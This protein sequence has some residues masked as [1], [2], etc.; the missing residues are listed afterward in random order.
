M[1]NRIVGRVMRLADFDYELPDERIAQH[2]VEPRDS[3][4]L[5]VDQGTAAPLHRHVAT[6]RSSCATATCWWSTTRR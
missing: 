4:R 5:L 3:A 6:S 2:P 1:G